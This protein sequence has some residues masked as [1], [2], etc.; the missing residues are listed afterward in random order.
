MSLLLCVFSLLFHN[1]THP[2]K[3]NKEA[4]RNIPRWYHCF[5]SAGCG[6][7]PGSSH[8]WFS[9]ARKQAKASIISA[10]MLRLMMIKNCPAKGGQGINHPNYSIPATML[11]LMVIRNH[12]AK[13]GQG[14]NHSGNYVKTNNDQ[15]LSDRKRSRYQSAQLLWR[16]MVI[17]K[18]SGR[19]RSRQ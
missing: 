6:T 5:P 9:P 11:R 13:R 1:I 14:I 17:R 8:G 7:F 4:D 19:M 3:W 15:K 10:T 2:F 12:L 16:L 18:P